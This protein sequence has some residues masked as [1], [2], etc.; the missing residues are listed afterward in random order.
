M[1]INERIRALR[2]DKDITQTELGKMLN[3]K[4]ITLSQYERG[5]RQIPNEIII[6]LA[7]IFDVTTDY[8]YGIEK[9]DKKDEVK[10]IKEQLEICK[11]EIEKLKTII[12]NIL[13]I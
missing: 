7:E 2:E 3:I 4:Q 10:E 1:E 11:I 13:K 5:K 9:K 12:N 6:K 8:I